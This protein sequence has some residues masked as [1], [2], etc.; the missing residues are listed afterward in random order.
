M[1][2]CIYRRGSPFIRGV[3]F[4]ADYAGTKTC[5]CVCCD[6]NAQT[7]Q[8]CM[9]M[10]LVAVIEGHPTGHAGIY[11]KIGNDFFLIHLKFEK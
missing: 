7:E 8:I 1:H 3:L 6:R 2:A 4:G 9:E 11:T 10:V 5:V